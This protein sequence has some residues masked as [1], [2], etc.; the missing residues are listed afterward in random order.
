MSNEFSEQVAEDLRADVETARAKGAPEL[1]E[2]RKKREHYL[3]WATR[4]ENLFEQEDMAKWPR[5]Y[6]LRKPI[7]GSL[8]AERLDV[9]DEIHNLG[10]FINEKT[11]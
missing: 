1:I 4:L 8:A 6:R 2:A 10:G 3:A 9:V 11:N 7:P 5:I